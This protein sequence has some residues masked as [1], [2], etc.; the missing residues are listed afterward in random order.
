[1]NKSGQAAMEFLMTYGWAL[2]VVLIAIAA[3]AFFGV[4]NPGKFLPESC[5]IGAPGFACNDKKI[6]STVATFVVQNGLGS[7]IATGSTLTLDG[8]ENHGATCLATSGG[9]STVLDGRSTT[10]TVSVTGCGL[11][12]GTKFKAKTILSYQPVGGIAHT[13]IG[14]VVGKAEAV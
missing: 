8:T 2:L 13:L 6:T 3:L 5:V 12:A 11:V 4:L 14:D 1:M 9:A 10:Y 7:N